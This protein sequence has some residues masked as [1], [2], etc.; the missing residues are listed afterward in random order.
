MRTMRL[1]PSSPLRRTA[2]LAFA[3]AMGAAVAGPAPA[4]AYRRMDPDQRERF[5]Q[6]LRDRDAQRAERARGDSGRG[7]PARGDSA[8]GDRPRGDNARHGA[9]PPSRDSR[10]SPVERERLRQQ[11]RDARSRELRRGGSRNDGSRND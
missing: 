9:P 3:L 1:G 8:R 5:R 10:L 2:L 6:Q 11:L 7:D 4:Q